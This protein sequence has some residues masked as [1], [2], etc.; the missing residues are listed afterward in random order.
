[1]AGTVLLALFS[2][3]GLDVNGPIVRIVPGLPAEWRRMRYSILF[4]GLRYQFE[5][6]HETVSVCVDGDAEVI[7]GDTTVAV[8]QGEWTTV[9]T[10]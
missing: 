8:P 3:G 5:V 7:V 6:N 9:E 10:G 1:M 2:Y 4:R